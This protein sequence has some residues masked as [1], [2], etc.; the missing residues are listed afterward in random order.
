MKGEA[1]GSESAGPSGGVRV[2]LLA[3]SKY[4]RGARFQLTLLSVTF[5]PVL[6]DE[7]NVVHAKEDGVVGT[8]LPVRFAA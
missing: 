2:R 1:D 3:C 4:A 6:V 8:P 7:G 5:R